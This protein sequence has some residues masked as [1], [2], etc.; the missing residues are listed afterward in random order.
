MLTAP[1]RP[2][3]RW[4]GNWDSSDA[5][6]DCSAFV[7]AYR[8]FMVVFNVKSGSICATGMWAIS[9]NLL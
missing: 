2:S 6:H 1:S 8:E 9:S 7:H 3:P 5:Q 4:A